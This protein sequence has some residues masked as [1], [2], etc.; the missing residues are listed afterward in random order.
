MNK[1]KK[2]KSLVMRASLD[3]TQHNRK[4]FDFASLSH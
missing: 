2:V 3:V 4:K 1:A